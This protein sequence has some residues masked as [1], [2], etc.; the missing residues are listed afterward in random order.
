[1]EQASGGGEEVDCCRNVS[2]RTRSVIRLLIAAVCLAGVVVYL[3]KTM[4][5]SKQR[6]IENSRLIPFLNP[7]NVDRIEFVDSGNRFLVVERQNGRWMQVYPVCYPANPTK[8]EN[9]LTNLGGLE[10]VKK[11]AVNEVSLEG[12]GLQTY[13]L[14]P[15]R[16]QVQIDQRG[17]QWTLNIGDL[18]PIGDG[19]YC[20]VDADGP[21]LVVSANLWRQLP[22]SAV[23]WRDPVLVEDT[24]G[25]TRIVVRSGQQVVEFVRSDQGWMMTRP[26][27]AKAQ[28]RLIDYQLRLLELTPI[29]MFVCEEVIS[30]PDPYGTEQP[31]FELSLWRGQ[32]TMAEFAVGN[33]VDGKPDLLYVRNKAYSPVMAVPRSGLERWF[34][35]YDQFLDRHLFLFNPGEVFSIRYKGSSAFTVHRVQTN[36][37]EIIEPYN[38]EADP[39]LVAELLDRLL[40]W[41]A[42]RLVTPNM[43]QTPAVLSGGE[44]WEIGLLSDKTKRWQKVVLSQ[45]EARL[46][47]ATRE[48]EEIVLVVPDLVGLPRSAL[49]LRSR[50][51]WSI[52]TNS[53]ERIRAVQHGRIVEYRK[54]GNGAWFDGKSGA[55]VTSITFGETIYRLGNLS[56]IRW[57]ASGEENKIVFGFDETDTRVELDVVDKEMARTHSIEL[58]GRTPGGGRYAAIWLDDQDGLVIFELGQDVVAMLQQ[59]ILVR[60]LD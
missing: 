23:E 54:G 47:Y 20:Q 29:S 4:P 3:N 25:V 30:A 37:W 2:M 11:L 53:I 44:E 50:H 35:H 39:Y 40:Q 17:K 15:P 55:P 18:T 57:V 43:M 42:T 49:F 31:L 58:G 46:R 34:R 13:G 41:E 52:D 8:I 28:A 21:I 26:L 6:Q 16:L 56:A 48:G 51:I 24:G 27:R 9:F 1:M 45:P 14:K 5:G 12:K 36:R 22:R 19:V 59:D 7:L 32:T 10:I 33:E 38:A 60:P